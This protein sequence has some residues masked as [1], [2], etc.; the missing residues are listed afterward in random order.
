MRRGLRRLLVTVLAFGAA[1]QGPFLAYGAQAIEPLR[2]FEVGAVSMAALRGTPVPALQDAGPLAADPAV[3]RVGPDWG[4]TPGSLCTADD[5]DF[6]G[7]RYPVQLAHCKRRVSR[8]DKRRVAQAYGIPESE[9]SNYE[10]DHLLPLAIGG[11]NGVENLWPQPHGD[12]ESYSKDKLE[13]ELYHALRKGLITQEEAVRRTYAWFKAKG[14]RL[15][16]VPG[17]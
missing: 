12:D 10:F 9:W 2:T 17:V 8:G 4:V 16:R 3:N 7:F 1:L 15:V 14:I 11:S 6:D 13:M 5:P